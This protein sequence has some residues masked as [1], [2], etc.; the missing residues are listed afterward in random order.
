MS[1]MD[2]LGLIGVVMLIG[3]FIG[4]IMSFIYGNDAVGLLSALVGMIGFIFTVFHLDRVMEAIDDIRREVELEAA[5]A[6]RI[7][8]QIRR[9]VNE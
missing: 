8:N 9:E 4:T 3:G 6:Q 1:K 2:C 5:R 7:I